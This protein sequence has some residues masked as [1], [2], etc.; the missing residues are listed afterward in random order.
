MKFEDMKKIWDEQREEH[1]YV[2]N[3]QQ[4]HENIKSRK[5]GASRMVNKMELFLLG[6]NGITGATLIV[7]NYV[8]RSGEVL[9]GTLMGLFLLGMAAF[10]WVRR[11]TRLKH[12]NR[13]DRTMLGDINHAIENATYQVR[14][15]YAMLLTVVP[16]FSL[17]FMGAWK[18][19]K[20][21]VV[22]G[23]I[24]AMFVL[25]F[26]LGRWEHRGLHVARK[27]RLEAIREKL[28]SEN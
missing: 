24:A 3:E 10:I 9:F 20:S 5:Q 17:A 8:D 19:G 14:L 15:S 25:A 12:E 26:F 6:V 28:T 11:R 18:E 23:F 2:I 1:V 22:L 27:K 4:L 7:L 16:V 13:F 21:P